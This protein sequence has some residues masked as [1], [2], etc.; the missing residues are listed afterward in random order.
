[1]KNPEF[2]FLM[3]FWKKKFNFNSGFGSGSS[4]SV[5][6]LLGTKLYFLENLANL[7]FCVF[8]P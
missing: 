1:M 6:R 7:E 5:I 2:L 4:S 3:V 8:V